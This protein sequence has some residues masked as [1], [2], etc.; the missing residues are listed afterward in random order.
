MITLIMYTSEHFLNTFPIIII[1]LWW[2]RVEKSVITATCKMK[3]IYYVICIHTGYSVVVLGFH[4]AVN[5][6]HFAVVFSAILVKG[7]NN[8]ILVKIVLY[9]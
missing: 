6:M 2:I 9:I 4:R 7:I 3:S 1:Y 8:N 5:I